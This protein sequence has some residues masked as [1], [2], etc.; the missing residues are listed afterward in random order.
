MIATRALTL[1]LVGAQFSALAHGQVPTVHEDAVMMIADP[2]PY[3]FLGLDV[4]ASDTHVLVGAPNFDGVA[5]NAGVAFLYRRTPEGWSMVQEL[6]SWN[7][8]PAQQFGLHVSLSER[9]AAINVRSDSGQ[10]N[11]G[12]VY[13]FRREGDQW[14]PDERIGPH[15]DG[16]AL[17]FAWAALQV[18]D[19]MLFIGH[20]AHVDIYRRLASGWERQGRVGLSPAFSDPP[21]VHG[22]AS[23]DSDDRTLIIGHLGSDLASVYE[24]QGKEW[25]LAAVLPNPNPV[26]DDDFGWSVAVE[27]DTVV[28]GNPVFQAF[29]PRAGVVY[30]YRRKLSGWTLKQTLK[31]KLGGGSFDRFGFRVQ[32]RGG[33]LIIPAPLEEDAEGNRGAIYLYERAGKNKQG[34]FKKIRKMIVDDPE[35]SGGILEFSQGFVVAGGPG[36]DGRD[37]PSVGA[38]YIF[39]L[40]LGEVFCRSAPNSVSAGATLTAKGSLAAESGALELVAAGLP[41]RSSGFFL[42]SRTRGFQPKPG[43]GVGTLCLGDPMAILAPPGPA[44][45]EG[46]LTL[47]LDLDFIPLGPGVPVLS[48][49]TWCFQL[50]YRDALKPGAPSNFSEA[51]AVSFL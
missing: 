16:P 50:W 39:D 47:A 3:D 44:N 33:K 42:A 20:F 14:F 24:R 27:G 36:K 13:V 34:K 49:E 11:A 32:L 5:A 12:A 7:P 29:S 8:E 46:V 1:L 17:G 38:A 40:P 28:V 22:V 21:E 45:G 10:D 18:T 25:V 31:R 26:Q 9:F 51:L 19:R 23:L 43:P 30:V 2:G 15:P 37:F 6:R 48:G 41:P 35:V 4:A